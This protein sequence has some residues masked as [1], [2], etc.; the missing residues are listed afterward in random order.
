MSW[1]KG[2]VFSTD[3]S[4][5]RP[6]RSAKKARLAQQFLVVGFWDWVVGK[7]HQP[8]PSI[9]VLCANDIPGICY[10]LKSRYDS[11]EALS[12]GAFCVL[13]SLQG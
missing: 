10:I 3:E 13:C 7:R 5:G 11:G 12:G 8:F 4:P 1:L 6:G 9:L 2:N